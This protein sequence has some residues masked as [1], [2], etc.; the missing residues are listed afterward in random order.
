MR[1]TTPGGSRPAHAR[2]CAIAWHHGD[3]QEGKARRILIVDD[4]EDVRELLGEAL[5]FLGHSSVEAADGREALAAMGGPNPIELVLLDLTMPIMSG[6]E[7]LRERAKDP[8]LAQVPVV[9]ISARSP[10]TKDLADVAETLIK[11]ITLAELE[12]TIDRVCR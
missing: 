1:T 11:P 9:V 3:V 12:R 7:F 5:S 6:A 2:G 10:H 4:D 8:K